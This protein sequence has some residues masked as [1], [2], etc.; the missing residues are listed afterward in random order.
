MTRPVAV[1]IIT[2]T[3]I[4]EHSFWPYGR[5]AHRVATSSRARAI[6]AGR[7]YHHRHIVSGYRRDRVSTSCVSLNAALPL[8]IFNY[9]NQFLLK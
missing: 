7:R 2:R 3:V 6:D 4:A 9:Q 5:T 8:I 1:R